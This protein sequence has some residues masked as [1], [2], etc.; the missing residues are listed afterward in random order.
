MLTILKEWHVFVWKDARDNPFVTVTSSHFITWL[1]FTFHSNE[2][3]DHL[4]HTR[5]QIVATTDFFNLV[6][7]T[8]VQSTFLCFVLLVQRL[9]DLCVLLV[10]QCEHPPL[11]TA[12]AVQQLFGDDRTCLDAFGAFDSGFAKQHAAQTCIDVAVKNAEFVVPVTGQTFDFLTLDLQRTFVFFDAVTVEDPN[13]DHGTIVARLHAQRGVAHVRCL[14]AKDGAQQ[15]FFRGHRAFALWCD[16]ANQN[17]ARLHVSTDVHDASLVEVAQ[18]FFTDVRDVASDFFRTKLGVTCG[19]FEFLDVD[20]GED[21]VTRDALGDQDGV[22]VVVTV[23][24]HERDD[25]VL[26]Q[27]QFTHIG[28]RTIGNHFAL[29]DLLTYF[30]QRTLVDAGVLVGTLELAHAVDINARVAQLQIFGCP[31]HDTLCVDLVDDACT[32]GHDGRAG[33]PCHDLF[34][35]GTDQRRFCAQQRNRLTLHVRTHESAVRVVVFQERN[36]RG[37]NRDQL[38]R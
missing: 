23:P 34:D 16:L 29:A 27:S 11:T 20:R 24:R 36:E 3:F 25:D 38:L 21:V 33:I 30:H 18:R 35:A 12:Q 28:G 17:I 15:L 8:G 6:F 9:N 1:N 5:R 7:K 4:H 14:F 26:T 31:D 37:R 22:F 2:D 19:D 13:L 32:L 10:F